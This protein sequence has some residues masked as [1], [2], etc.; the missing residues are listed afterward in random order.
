MNTRLSLRAAGWRAASVL[1][2]SFCAFLWPAAAFAQ[3]AASDSGPREFTIGI[4]EV[5]KRTI[6][7]DDFT[8]EEAIGEIA[9]HARALH[10]IVERDLAYSA[11]FTVRRPP[12]PDASLAEQAAPVRGECI[13]SAKIS[14]GRRGFE[15]AGTLTEPRTSRRIASYSYEFDAATASLTA[16]RYA[17]DIIFHLTGEEGIAR[18]R[19]AFVGRNRDGQELY[20]TD[21][22]GANTTRVTNDK[23][24]TISPD[25]SPD[26]GAILYTS[27][28]RGNAAVYWIRPDATEGG[29]VAQHQGLNSAAA[30][31]ADGK[32][33]A[34]AL[35]KDGNQE[36][37]TMRR[38]ATSL[39]RLTVN[40]AIDTS[41]SWSPTGRQIVFTSDR[42]G[43]PQLFIMES[44]G[45]NQRR[46]TFEGD[47]NASPAWSP[48]GQSIVYVSRT[49]SG[50][51][52]YMLDPVNQTTAPITRGRHLY[53][54][55]AWAP[56]GRQIVA[57]RNSGGARSIVV[58]NAD[59]SDER[60]LP[61]GG[62][63]AFS[64]T[65]SPR[66]K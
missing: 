43:S 13:V 42:T 65:W 26:G 6:I 1:L 4:S 44:D 5:G 49:S 19:I 37:Y 29:A 23:S 36:I 41:P 48:D 40:K 21:Y 66:L 60:V 30:W 8:A 38:D 9:D 52:L 34:V 39:T 14:R 12:G 47:Y 16:H 62:L 24:I 32:R 15:L 56:N 57:T 58:M 53:E 50:F 64:P 55:P 18:T 7:L 45:S 27:F 25:W 46:A 28:K 2:A 35:S 11:I 10:D 63:D 33:L 31:A 17:D 59:G 61:S 51:D 3:T 22:D 20:I 54:D